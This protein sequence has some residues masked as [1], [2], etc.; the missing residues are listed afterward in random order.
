LGEERA[1]TGGPQV[2]VTMAWEMAIGR[3]TRG[4]GPGDTAVLGRR[5]ENDPRPLFQFNF[6][7]LF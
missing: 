1:L 6:L 7:F 3:L 2:A 4:I 5:G